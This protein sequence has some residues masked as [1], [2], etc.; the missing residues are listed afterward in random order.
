M[1]IQGSTE[2]SHLVPGGAGPCS[3]T[4]RDA[5]GHRIEMHASEDDV[6]RS[7]NKVRSDWQG[8]GLGVHQG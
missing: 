8:K 2:A 7:A 3:A 5:V 1:G 4:R 6:S